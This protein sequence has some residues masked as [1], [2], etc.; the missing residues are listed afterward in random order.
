MF[1]T[2]NAKLRCLIFTTVLLGAAY[3][4]SLFVR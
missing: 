4:F 2:M 1:E 3:G